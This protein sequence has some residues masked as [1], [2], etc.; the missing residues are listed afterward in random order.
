MQCVY[1]KRAKK[2]INKVIPTILFVDYLILALSFCK[3]VLK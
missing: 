3:I 2:F 1:K